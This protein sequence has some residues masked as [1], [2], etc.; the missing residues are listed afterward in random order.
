[1][2]NETM[3]SE[4]VPFADLKEAALRSA[5]AVRGMM[6]LNEMAGVRRSKHTGSV[7]PP[8]LRK[9]RRRA[10]AKRA[11]VSRRINRG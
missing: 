10:A 1:M 5:A 8:E 6:N 3:K 4:A 7:V 11:K 9:Q 2:E